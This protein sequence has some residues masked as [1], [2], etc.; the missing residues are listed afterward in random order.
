M[1]FGDISRFH[2]IS[3]YLPILNG[4]VIADIVVIFILY[5]TPY[6]NSR[7]LSK[8]Y[9]KYHL[10]AAIADI[11]ILVIGMV[12]TRMVFS[13]FQLDWNLL[14]FILIALVI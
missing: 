6:F 4:S 7:F 2:Q 10:G 1:I 9:S 14:Y 8:W 3:D 12:L 5:Y 13:Y 11:L